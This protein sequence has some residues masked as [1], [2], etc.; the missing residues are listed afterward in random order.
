MRSAQNVFIDEELS[1]AQTMLGVELALEDGNNKV[2]IDTLL[3][4]T[5]IME[6]D[7]Q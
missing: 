4:K 7:M 2:Q 3:K 6:N 5:Q 1:Q